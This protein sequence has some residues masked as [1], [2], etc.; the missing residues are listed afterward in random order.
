MRNSE[1]KTRPISE[2]MFLD[3]PE[4]ERE[5]NFLPKPKVPKTQGHFSKSHH[6]AD[7]LPREFVI[8]AQVAKNFFDAPEYFTLQGF[9]DHAD[10]FKTQYF[11]KKKSTDVCFIHTIKVKL[12]FRSV[13][14]ILNLSSGEISRTS[15][16]NS[17]LSMAQISILVTLEVD[18]QSCLKAKK[19]VI[20]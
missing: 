5:A 9:K 10:K 7:R 18:F 20:K 3:L 14:R 15:T 4:L 13:L 12:I 2:E 17:M 6:S 19:S 11:K 16:P 8:S 1:E